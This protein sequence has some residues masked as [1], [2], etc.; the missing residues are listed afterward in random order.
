VQ[1]KKEKSRKIKAEEKKLRKNACA[2][3]Y[4]KKK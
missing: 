4:I 1:G 3:A 2:L